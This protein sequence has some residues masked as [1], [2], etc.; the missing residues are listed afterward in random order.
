LLLKIFNSYIS[1]ELNKQLFTSV[2]GR[3]TVTGC[4]CFPAG[5]TLGLEA[6]LPSGVFGQENQLEAVVANIEERAP[7]FRG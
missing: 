5:Y 4:L 1:Y 6:D 3:F 2:L 7:K